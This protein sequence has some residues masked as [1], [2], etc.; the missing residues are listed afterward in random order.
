MEAR[1]VLESMKSKQRLELIEGLHVILMRYHQNLAK[2]Q[3]EG[4]FSSLYLLGTIQVSSDESSKGYFRELLSDLLTS[5]SLPEPSTLTFWSLLARNPSEDLLSLNLLPLLTMALQANPSGLMFNPSFQRSYLAILYAHIKHGIDLADE[6]M[7]KHV[8]DIVAYSGG[9]GAAGETLGYAFRCLKLFSNSKENAIRL[10]QLMD[11]YS[12][13]KI[14]SFIV[15]FACTTSTED[16]KIF[17][18]EARDLISRLAGKL[19]G[20]FLSDWIQDDLIGRCSIC[21][22]VCL[23]IKLAVV[24]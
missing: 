15:N 7:I 4:A 20:K 11:Y 10:L 6:V 2:D 17:A 8:V 14:A 23:M 19:E 24:N 18:R 22:K 5:P 1:D 3:V 21:D 13:G 16:D 12:P 9:P